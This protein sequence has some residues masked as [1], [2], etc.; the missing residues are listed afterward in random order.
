MASFTLRLANLRDDSPTHPLGSL[1]DSQS[2]CGRCNKLCPSRVSN[3]DSPVTQP[4]AQ[5]VQTP[6]YNCLTDEKT[7]KCVKTV[8]NK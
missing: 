5:S 8:N 4:A 1:S 3:T 7:H 6:A 2:Q